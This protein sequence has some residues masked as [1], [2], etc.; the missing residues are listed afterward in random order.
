MQIN[1]QRK[2]VK[3][4]I[5]EIVNLMVF[6]VIFWRGQ[7]VDQGP[8]ISPGQIYLTSESDDKSRTN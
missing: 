5:L 4:E 8:W 7:T 6:S 2:S 3:L 1:G